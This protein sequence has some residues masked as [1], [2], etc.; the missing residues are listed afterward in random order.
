[1]DGTKWTNDQPRKST[2][3]V[4]TLPS[5]TPTTE[6]LWICSA[7]A[8]D[9]VGVSSSTTGTIYVENG[10]PPEGTGADSTCPSTD[11]LSILDDGHAN[12]GDD[13]VYWINPD[14]GGFIKPIVT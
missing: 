5:S 3:P 1:M 4:D 8:S 2:G 11:C 13:G 7:E 12:V 10:C 9:G 14:G 6:G